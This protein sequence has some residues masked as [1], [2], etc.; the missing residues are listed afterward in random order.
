MHFLLLHSTF[1][2]LS[3]AIINHIH[4]HASCM[5][6]QQSQSRPA[7]IILGGW[8]PGPLLY[9][10]EFL[11]SQQC[12]ILQPRNLPMPPI[13]GSWCCDPK[14][15]LMILALVGIQWVLH[16]FNDGLQWVFISIVVTLV[17]FRLLV[18]VVVRASIERSVKISLKCLREQE[19][20]EIILIGFS[21]GGAVSVILRV[22]DH[23]ILACQNRTPLP[24]LSNKCHFC[25]I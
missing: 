12:D 23:R 11:S 8:S 5:M 18:A 25:G 6:N 20:R 3:S 13:P 21:W 1:R 24:K 22:I 4:S 16:S 15:L 2:S 17:W 10:I 9:L 7:V 14:V 19:G